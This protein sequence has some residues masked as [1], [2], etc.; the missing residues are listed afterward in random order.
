MAQGIF[1]GFR[2]DRAKKI[3]SG[4]DSK[5]TYFQTEHIQEEKSIMK[6]FVEDQ[7][8]APERLSPVWCNLRLI[9]VKCAL[10]KQA[11]GQ[12]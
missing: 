6:S 7:T 9:G 10:V 2:D 8:H 3:F 12:P 4:V 11:A 1:A 5:D